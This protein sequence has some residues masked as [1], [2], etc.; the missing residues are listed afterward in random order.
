MG[1]RINTNMASL[2]AQRA[3]TTTTSEQH[4]NYSRLATGNR[5]VAAG[6]DAA[7]LS[8]SENLRGQIRSMAQ[9]ERNTNEAVSFIQVAEGSTAEISS[10]LIRMRELAIQGASDTVGDK[11]RGFINQEYQALVGEVDRIAESTSFNG[12]ALLNGD[13]NKEMLVFQVGTENKESNR[14]EYNVRENNVK[15]D[16]IG[17][18]DVKALTI[19]DAREAIDSI[20]GAIGKVSE[21][22]ARL[23]AMQNKLFSTARNVGVQK[24]NLVQ[25]RSRIADADVAEVSSNLVRDNILSSAGVTCWPR[26]TPPPPKLSS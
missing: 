9:A 23:G 7:G 2:H 8:I 21:T 11:E 26:P 1:L 6:D 10:I 20:D 12:T 24:E 15:A 4:K 19:T 17:I 14:I 18:K 22:R 13:S 5:I 25:A 3:L 16:A